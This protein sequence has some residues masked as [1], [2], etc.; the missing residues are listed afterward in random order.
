MIGLGWF[1]TTPHGSKVLGHGG[2]TAGFQTY[3]AFDP[4]AKRGVVVLSNSST[5]VSDLAM[6]ILDA[7]NPLKTFEPAKTYTR[8]KIDPASFDAVV[9]R[10]DMAPGAAGGSSQTAD[11]TRVGDQ[12]FATV[13]GMGKVEIFAYE[14]LSFFTELLDMQFMFAPE[15]SGVTL[16]VR[17]SGMPLQAKR[18]R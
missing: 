3:A 9:G 4:T 10:Y 8:I 17:Q 15:Q 6:H 18:L 7:R 1:I 12:F 11:F 16:Y 5:E 2:G 13:A 14:P